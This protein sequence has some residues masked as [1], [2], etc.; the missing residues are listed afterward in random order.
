VH[1]TPASASI[2]YTALVTCR[3]ST[4]RQLLPS[5]VCTSAVV[6]CIHTFE[7]LYVTYGTHSTLVFTASHLYA[8][9]R[10]TI[11]HLREVRPREL[12]D[13]AHRTVVLHCSVWVK[14]LCAVA[15]RWTVYHVTLTSD[16]PVLAMGTHNQRRTGSSALCLC[17]VVVMLLLVLSLLLL[18]SAHSI[19]PLQH[20]YKVH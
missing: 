20:S 15:C 8:C 17:T 19:R 5:T 18:C 16:A 2:T 11:A 14:L 3:H 13:Y 1:P 7:R 4:T 6:T 12:E 9:C 10:H